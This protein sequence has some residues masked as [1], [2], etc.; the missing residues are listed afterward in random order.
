V[1]IGRRVL[2]QVA[3]EQG[4]P[5]RGGRRPGRPPGP[6]PRLARP[7]PPQDPN[8]L[9]TAGIEG[10]FSELSGGGDRG[11]NPVG[12]GADPDWA[13]RT[14]Q[15]FD[16]NHAHAAVDFAGFHL[17][18]DNWGQ[19]DQ[20]TGFLTRFVRDRE[21]AAAAL[22]KPL[23]AEEFGKEGGP[24]TKDPYFSAMFGLVE[25]SVARGGALQ[26]SLFWQFDVDGRDASANAVRQSDSTFALA[27]DN[28]GRLNARARGERVPG[29]VPGS[30][31]SA[32]LG[33]GGASVCGGGGSGGALPENRPARPLPPP[34]ADATGRF[35]S[36]GDGVSS[37]SASTLRRLSGDAAACADAC[38]AAPTCA[39]FTSGGGACELH[40][41][42]EPCPQWSPGRATYWPRTVADVAAVTGSVVTAFSA[43]GG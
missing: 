37:C 13:E 16:R 23:L 4:G 43:D 12:A 38:R 14:G 33:E 29:C 34:P 15:D 40:S 41:R 32:Q 30:V 6:R 28:A 17:W 8:H 21:S 31:R 2:R 1:G 26:G 35:V 9:V 22:G 20:G 27:R 25:A 10:F 39:A 42:A 3:G 19:E 7:R 18:V 11:T 36:L 5:A 24:S